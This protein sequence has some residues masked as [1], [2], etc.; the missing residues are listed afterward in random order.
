MSIFS[1]MKKK[2]RKAH[3][4]KGIKMRSVCNRALA[5]VI[6]ISN[7]DDAVLGDVVAGTDD[8]LGKIWEMKNLLHA[9]HGEP[10]CDL[11][12]LADIEDKVEAGIEKAKSREKSLGGQARVGDLFT[13]AW[14]ISHEKAMK[15][16]LKLKSVSEILEA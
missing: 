16:T 13:K 2:G 9:G 15:G 4:A 3:K 10:P 11:S 6:H 12:E 7:Q 1:R 14:A 5:E 8:L